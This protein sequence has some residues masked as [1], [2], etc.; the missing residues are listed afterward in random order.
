MLNME[1][2]QHFLKEVRYLGHIVSPEGI[3]IDP[4]KP[5]AVRE[6]PTTKNKHE[7]TSFLCLRPYYRQLISRFAYIAKPVTKLTQ[8]NQA[9]QCSPDVEAAFQTLKEALCTAPVLAYPQ[10]RGRFFGDTDASN[11]GIGEVLSQVQDEQDR[12]TAHYNMTLNKA[13]RNEGVTRRELL[14]IVR[15]VEHFHTST[16]KSSTCAPT[17]LH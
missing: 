13:E 11:V 9:S 2:C 5:K 8:E 17:T 15:T 10:P 6:Y 3:T 12:L 14:A 16:D 7:I 1:K 4:V